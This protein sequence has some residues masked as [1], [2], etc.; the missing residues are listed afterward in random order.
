MR[1]RWIILLIILGL[2]AALLVYR[3][4]QPEATLAVVQPRLGTIRTYVEELATTELPHEHLVAMPIPGWLNRIDLREGDPVAQGQVIATLDTADLIDR[5]E[6]AEQR[7]AALQANIAKVA[8]NTLE[9]DALIQANAVVKAMNETVEAAEAKLQAS[10]AVAEFAEYDVQ[11]LRGL[12]QR[13]AAAERELH[14]AEANWRK[15]EADHQSDALN[16]AALK[17]LAAVSYITPKLIHDYI[18]KKQYDKQAYE[19]QLAEAR[20]QLAIEKRN[21]ERATITS[22]I[23]GLVLRRHETRRQYL[24]A[25]TPL[26]TLGNL[27]NLEVIAEVLTER[28]MRISP[29]DPVEITGEGLPD[30][31]IA[32]KVLRVYPAGFEKISSLG[33]EQQRVNVAIAMDKRPPPL[34]V[35]FRVDVR[36]FYGT[37]ENALVLPRTS[38]FRG[39]GDE[40]MAMTVRAGRT[41]LQR[42]RVGL[43]NDQEAQVLEGLAAD[44][45]V[46][47]RPSREIEPGMRVETTLSR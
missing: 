6:Q 25:G 44:D 4:R 8:D 32:G 2:M 24:Q 20:A 21:L 39:A 47:A 7:I 45:R 46:V 34:G 1:G 42:V 18:A 10:R 33:V 16:L 40:W 11:R 13:D 29:G 22:P 17:T 26:L 41:H 19:R 36:I 12:A 30:G 15:A 28:A 9:N 27:D 3:F 38:L 14:A 31:P 37:A 43:L 35:A 23:D 5:V